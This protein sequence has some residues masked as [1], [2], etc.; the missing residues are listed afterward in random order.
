MSARVLVTGAA[1]GIGAATASA[2]RARG[3]RV[4]GLDLGA[5]TVLVDGVGG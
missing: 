4:I 3:C 5:V 1:S 2:L